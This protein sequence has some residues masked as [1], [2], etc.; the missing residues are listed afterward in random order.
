MTNMDRL[1][2][3]AFLTAIWVFVTAGEPSDW[4]FAFGYS[5]RYAA[6]CIWM[7][8]IMWRKEK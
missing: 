3:F 7:W 2:I 1:W 6:L 4:D 5:M 8:M